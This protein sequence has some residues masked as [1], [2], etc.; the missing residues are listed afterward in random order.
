MNQAQKDQIL[1]FKDLWKPYGILDFSDD[2]GG[3]DIDPMRT[4]LGVPLAGLMPD[5]H[6][7]DIHHTAN[8][9]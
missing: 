9:F 5:C 7:F 4:K 1:D 3:T 2:E 8:S 6:V